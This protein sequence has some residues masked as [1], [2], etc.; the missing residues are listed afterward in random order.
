M[1]R[2][3][4]TGPIA[5]RLFLSIRSRALLMLSLLLAGVIATAADAVTAFDDFEA[6]AE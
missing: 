6:V 5:P 1:K 3:Q 4:T 2:D